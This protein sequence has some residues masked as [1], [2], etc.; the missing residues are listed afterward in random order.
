M[1][2]A[3]IADPHVHD[4]QFDPRDDG[5][6]AFRTFADTVG[7]TRVFNESL[8]AFRQALEQIVAA[9]ITLVVIVGDLT[10]D[11]ELYARRALLALTDHYAS[12]HGLRFFATFG[13]H[14]L[15]ALDGRHMA[16]RFARQAQGDD[17]VGS[18][19]DAGVVNAEMYCPGYAETLASYGA[20]GFM[21]QPQDRHWESPFG[22]SDDAAAR[23]YSVTSPDGE[24]RC[25]MIDG[26]YLVEPVEGLW[27]LSIDANVYLPGA[28]GFADCSEEGWGAVIRHKP[29]L[30]DWIAGV[31]DRAAQLGKRLV[32]FSHYSVA[33]PFPGAAADEARLFGLSRQTRRPVEP[34]VSRALLDAGLRVHFSGHWH[35]AGILER[36]GLVNVSVPSLV[37]FPA[38]YQVLDIEPDRTTLRTVCLDDPPGWE[39]A[40]G[41]YAREPGGSALAGATSYAGFL[42][43]H[44]GHLVRNRYLPLEWPAEIGEL[45]DFPI[46][47]FALD[48]YRLRKAGTL[49]HDLVPPHRIEAYRAAARSLETRNL[50]PEGGQAALAAAL[51]LME[52]C[53]AAPDLVDHQLKLGPAKLE[54]V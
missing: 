18:G 32:A 48:W 24:L 5:S 34:A 22:T 37:A 50:A 53:L 44:L 17:L 9:G 25:E 23:R 39:V 47:D 31:T 8:A 10:D 15:F 21:R 38:A 35:V 36:D 54:I 30:L 7:S 33:G 45:Q 16:K 49:A 19:Q 51:R 3:I 46:V 6:G 52:A 42:D 26:S 43:R 29:F 2:I 12:Q 41:I 20:L 13:N 27:L 4:P 28:T 14:D 40:R 11:G 1:R